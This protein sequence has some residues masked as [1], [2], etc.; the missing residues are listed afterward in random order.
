VKSPRAARFGPGG[1]VKRSLAM[2]FSR[3]G[4]IIGNPSA[5]SLPG[6]HGGGFRPPV[7]LSLEEGGGPPL[8]PLPSAGFSRR[9]FPSPAIVAISTSIYKQSTR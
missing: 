5:L 4:A 2:V 9:D 6:R 3:C 7:T 8:L 1:I